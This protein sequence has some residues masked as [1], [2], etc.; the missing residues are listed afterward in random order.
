MNAVVQLEPRA[1]VAERA[2]TTLQVQNFDQAI[3]LAQMMSEAQLVPV[4]LQKKPADCLLIVEQSARWNMSPFA[5]AQA[6]SVISGKLM[7]E[8]KLVTAALN[9]SGALSGRLRFDIE[10]E[11]DGLLCIASATIRGEQQARTVAVKIKDVRTGNKMWQSQ[12][13]QQLCY[14]AARVWGRRHLPEVMLGVYSPEEDFGE[15]LPTGQQGT[16]AKIEQPKPAIAEKQPY[17]DDKFAEN[18]PTWHG[19]I[20]SGKKTPQQIVSLLTSKATL[21]DQQHA[22][23]MELAEVVA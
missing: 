3:K 17:P 16:A 18:L 12:P 7:F 20:A 23:I 10:G 4:H 9:G 8:G 22:T 1:A 13:E 15:D 6:T 21:T 14:S 2:P 11:G 19:L 5:V